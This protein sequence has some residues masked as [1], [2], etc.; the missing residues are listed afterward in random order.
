MIHRKCWLWVQKAKPSGKPID[1]ASNTT[2]ASKWPKVTAYADI[3]P[4][5]NSPSSTQ[6]IYGATVRTEE[7]EAAHQDIDTIILDS[8]SDIQAAVESSKEESSESSDA[9]L[10]KYL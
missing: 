3:E 1:M 9:E 7:E 5:N 10:S 6:S 2:P 4:N 8:D